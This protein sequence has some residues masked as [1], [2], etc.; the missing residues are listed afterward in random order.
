MPELPEVESYCRYCSSV[1]LGKKISKVKTGSRKVLE[2]SA[3]TLRRHLLHNKL[4]SCKRHGKYL[5]MGISDGYLLSMHFG[6]SGYLDYAREEAP[7]HTHLSLTLPAGGELVYVCPRKFGRISIAESADAFVKEK[8]LGP[9][10]MEISKKD[11]AEKISGYNGSIK[12]ALMNQGLVAGIGN[13]YSDEILYQEGLLPERK[14]S[15]LESKK[16]KKMHSAMKRILNTAIRNKAE[17]EE[18]PARYLAGRRQEGSSCGIC[19]GKIKK[20]IH[21]G[22]PTYFCPNHQK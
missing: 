15:R 17:R 9:D 16:L 4:S 3:S 13:V 2:V 20:K 21:L 22:R 18:F 12:G 19:S 7:E 1:A 10:A 11:F 14:A 5:L 8:G 6:M